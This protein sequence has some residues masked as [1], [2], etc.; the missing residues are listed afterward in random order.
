MAATVTIS[1][2]VELAGLGKD[3]VMQ[4]VA[5]DATTPT[6]FTYNYRKLAVADT[7]EALDLGDVATV[8]G[9]WIRA[10]DYALYVDTSY[11]AA[12]SAEMTLAAGGPPAF[13]PTPSGTVYVKNVT[14]AQT[15]VYEA[16]VWG[17]T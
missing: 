3:L 1:N 12:F 15:P 2:R 5:V 7:A 16:V 17:T 11:V 9:I 13:I 10:I 6:A 14:A 8:T 4:D